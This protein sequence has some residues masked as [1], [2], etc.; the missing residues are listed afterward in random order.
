MTEFQLWVLNVL[1]SLPELE[2]TIPDFVYDFLQ[3]FINLM[4]CFVVYRDFVPILSA[5]VAYSFIS[6]T[7][8]LVN[9]VKS[10]KGVS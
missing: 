5:S 4:D 7:V 10:W 9:Y 3:D 2:F 6:L 8:T 1:D